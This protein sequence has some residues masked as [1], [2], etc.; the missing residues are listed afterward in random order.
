[1]QKNAW[2]TH[3]QRVDPFNVLF[4]IQITCPMALDDEYVIATTLVFLV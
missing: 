3:F 2:L 1:M 4:Y